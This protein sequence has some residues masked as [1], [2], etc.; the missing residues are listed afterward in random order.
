MTDQLKLFMEYK[1]KIKLAVGEEQT[2]AFI[3]KALFFICVGSDDIV[4]TYYSTILRSFEYDIDSYT[5]LTVSYA[6]QFFQV[7][8]H[9]GFS[10]MTN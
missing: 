4:N 9:F 6:A 10:Y 1:E 2:A 5:D 7:Y 8:A 3:S